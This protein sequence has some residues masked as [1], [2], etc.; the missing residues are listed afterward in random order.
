MTDEK[1]YPPTIN[2]FREDYPT[3]RDYIAD[4]R[5]LV[6]HYGKANKV[7]IFGGWKFFENG[8]DMEYWKETK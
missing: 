3:K 8:K 5:D 4:Y 6:Q 2:I 7:R 1:I